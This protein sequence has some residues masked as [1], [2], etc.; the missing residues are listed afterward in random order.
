MNKRSLSSAAGISFWSSPLGFLD[1][2]LVDE[3]GVRCPV[4]AEGE[5]GGGLF[6]VSPRHS[7]TP[8]AQGA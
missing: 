3:L 2:R 5:M 7:S 6:E 4:L 1:L 8:Y